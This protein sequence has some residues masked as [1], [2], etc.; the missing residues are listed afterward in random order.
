LTFQLG[1][2]GVAQITDMSVVSNQALVILN[3]RNLPI[4][5]QFN[6]QFFEICY[7]HISS[8]ILLSVLLK[9]IQGL[10]WL[11]HL[12]WHNSLNSVDVLINDQLPFIN[13]LV[14]SGQLR[15]Q[16]KFLFDWHK[17][18]AQ[19]VFRIQ[20]GCLRWR[21]RLSTHD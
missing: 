6:H 9:Q 20:L 18:L 14:L 13:R 1:Q 7:G 12:F 17:V 4:M 15:I 2:Y 8:L 21:C 11:R 10:H 19:V 3:V 16:L 5:F